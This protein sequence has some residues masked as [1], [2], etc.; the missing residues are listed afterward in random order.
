MYS[1][2]CV[3]G[4]PMS[5]VTR[6]TLSGYLIHLNHGP[7]GGVLLIAVL[8]C[9]HLPEHTICTLHALRCCSSAMQEVAFGKPLLPRTSKGVIDAA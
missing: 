2:A 6:E 8:A 5:E 3:Q 7:C 1:T 4:L 9:Q